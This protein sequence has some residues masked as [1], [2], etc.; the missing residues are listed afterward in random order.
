MKNIFLFLL[1]CPVFASSQ[2]RV[3]VIIDKVPAGTN[4][5]SIYIMG[6]FN[7]WS[8]ADPQS[9]LT[10]DQSGK[11]SKSYDDVQPALYEFKFTLGSLESVECK[12]DGSELSNRMLNLQSD[13]TIHITIARWKNAPKTAAAQKNIPANTET[14][15][16]LLPPERLVFYKPE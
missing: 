4:A 1:L 7:E 15:S 16:A 10:K 9:I 8:P 14:V 3:T 5:E 13:T 6:N 12:A 2:Y 11:Y